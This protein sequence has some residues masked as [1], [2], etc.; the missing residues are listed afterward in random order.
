MSYHTLLLIALHRPYSIVLA[1]LPFLT[2]VDLLFNLKIRIYR[3][4]LQAVVY[5]TFNKYSLQNLIILNITL[6][7][8]LINRSTIKIAFFI[9]L[10]K[11]KRSIK[12]KVKYKY[13][14]AYFNNLKIIKLDINKGNKLIKSSV[15]KDS[16]NAKNSFIKK[17]ALLNILNFFNLNKPKLINKL[18][19][20]RKVIIKRLIVI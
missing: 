13:Y 12:V 10:I 5:I 15:F 8:K 16:R 3:Q 1:I 17:A 19:D 2:K 6:E 18:K 14:Y 11:I 20:I 7:I 4:I 9:V